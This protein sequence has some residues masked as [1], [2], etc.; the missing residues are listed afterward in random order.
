[1]SPQSLLGALERRHELFCILRLFSEVLSDR[2]SGN[3]TKRKYSCLAPTCCEL[4]ATALPETS[5][6]GRG[7]GWLG[8]AVGWDLGSTTV[9]RMGVISALV[10]PSGSNLT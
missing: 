8:R 1:M 5:Q 6:R 2:S 7:T 3:K 9:H 4:Q 10:G